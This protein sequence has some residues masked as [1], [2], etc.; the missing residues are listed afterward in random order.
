MPRH[1]GPEAAKNL[2]RRQHEGFLEKYLFGDAILDIGYRGGHPDSQPITDKAIGID[3]D[4]PGYAG[5]TLPFPDASQDAVFASH[6][7]EHIEDWATSLVDWYRVLKI[8]G[9]MVIAV[10]HRDLY[11]R[12]PGPPSRF[13]A[14]H[15]RF[16][17]PASLLSEIEEALPVGGY[18]IRLLKDIDDGFDYTLPPDRHAV[19]CYEIELVLQKI[20]IPVYANALRSSPIAEEIVAFY[21]K[22]IGKALRA[23]HCGELCELKHI[24][25]ILAGLPLPPFLILEKELRGVVGMSD[26]RAKLVFEVQQILE[27]VL[28]RTPFDENWY[29]GAHPDVARALLEDRIASPHVHFLRHGYFEGRV[30]RA[31]D[32]IFG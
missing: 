30:S 9:H 21:A 14:D 5:K 24:Q 22:L 4:Y 32:P 13:N 6:V 1:L 20:M 2:D 28:E 27:P 25:E 10:P 16:Y 26:Q 18:R 23:R 11:E 29:L 31:H 19:G 15:K 8:G 12:K 17:T 7:L 3:L